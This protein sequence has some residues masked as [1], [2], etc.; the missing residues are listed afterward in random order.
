M[1]LGR[2]IGSGILGT[3]WGASV[4][5]LAILFSLL[6]ATSVPLKFPSVSVAQC[7]ISSGSRQGQIQR[8]DSDALHWTIPV[9]AFVILTSTRK[10]N[11]KFTQ[12]F[13]P[14]I[15][16]KGFHFNRPPPTD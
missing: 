3:A 11:W 16:T 5:T 1:P 12:P 7:S 14:A 10:A 6:I 15:Q 8:F 4:P 13:L 2:N 9:D